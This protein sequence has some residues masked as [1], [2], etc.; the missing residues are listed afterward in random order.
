MSCQPGS[1]KTGGRTKGAIN[2]RTKFGPKAH[3]T[4]ERL[5]IDP[6]EILLRFA[7]NDWENLGYVSRTRRML[8]KSGEVVE[9]DNI[10]PSD[11]I[12]AAKSAS[13]YLFPKR[14]SVELT[15]KDGQDIFNSLGLLVQSV[16][17]SDHGKSII[18][19]ETETNSD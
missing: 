2:K 7:A 4:A 3:E 17:A 10:E 15:G 9:I 16:L 14:K 5:G 18:D 13:E 12:Q 11:R 6:F 19:S 8:S 1:P